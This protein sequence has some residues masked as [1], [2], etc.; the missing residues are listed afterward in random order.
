MVEREGGMEGCG[1]KK[2][3]KEFSICKL[4]REGRKVGAKKDAYINI[5]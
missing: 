5:Y 3:G 1:I 2:K 4:C